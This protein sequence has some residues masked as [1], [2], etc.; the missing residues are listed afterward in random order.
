[1]IG[2]LEII[3]WSW[4]SLEILECSLRSWSSNGVA[5]FWNVIWDLAIIKWSWRFLECDLRSCDHQME[6]R[7]WNVIWDLVIIKWSWR[8]WNVVGDHD[9]QIE[10]WEIVKTHH[11]HYWLEIVK[12]LLYL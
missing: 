8:F 3:K 9:H 10:W 6:L 4:R 1:V 11:D 12:W 7:F 5:R 2:D